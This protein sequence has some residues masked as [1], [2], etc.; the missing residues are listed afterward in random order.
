MNESVSSLMRYDK[1]ILQYKY[2]III[3]LNTKSCQIGTEHTVEYCLNVVANYHYENDF[4]ITFNIF[5]SD[6]SAL[7]KHLIKGRF[8]KN[9]YYLI[10]GESRRKR[11]V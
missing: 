1:V 11:R 9:S 10:I 7:H 2:S 4:I 3:L 6:I 8:N 5:T